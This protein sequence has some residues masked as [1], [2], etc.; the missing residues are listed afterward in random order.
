VEAQVVRISL[1]M[2][3][4]IGLW[5]QRPESHRDP[6]IAQLAG[7]YGPAVDTAWQPAEMQ[8]TMPTMKAITAR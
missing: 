2:G 8:Q 7:W 3:K 4:P 1:N 6:T 5:A